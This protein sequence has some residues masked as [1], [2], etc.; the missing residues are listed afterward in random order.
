MNLGN[1]I[2]KGVKGYTNVVDKVL[3]SPTL[4]MAIAGASGVPGMDKILNGIE[5]LIPDGGIN[6]GPK[7][8]SKTPISQATNKA[9]VGVPVDGT[10]TTTTTFDWKQWSTYP[11][12]AKYCIY[13]V[14]PAGLLLWVLFDGKK[15]NRSKKW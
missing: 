7:S 6:L 10:T 9:G 2:N 14:V 11:Q 15:M 3:K 4:N 1:L 12:W 13:A 8:I 5:K